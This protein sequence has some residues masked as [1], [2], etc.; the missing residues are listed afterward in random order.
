M[1]KKNE[2]QGNKKLNVLFLIADDLNCDLGSYN[3]FQVISPSIDKLASNGVLFEN[4][5]S[6]ST[7]R[8][9][10]ASFMTYVLGS[11]QNHSK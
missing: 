6:I 3:Q 8:P 11:N 4:A 1:R 7:V 10:R 9:S 5:Q 2:T